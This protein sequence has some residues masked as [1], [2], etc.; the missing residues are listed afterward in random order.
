MSWNTKFLGRKF[1]LVKTET[2]HVDDFD[3]AW[4]LWFGC[5]DKSPL[6][7]AQ[8]PTGASSPSPP[9]ALP[10]R[11]QGSASTSLHHTSH[12]TASLSY[13]VAFPR[14][15][16]YTWKMWNAESLRKRLY[17]ILERDIMPGSDTFI[18]WRNC[19][20]QSNREVEKK[21]KIWPKLVKW[22]PIKIS[23]NVKDLKDGSSLLHCSTLG[24]V[25]VLGVG[26]LHMP[27]PVSSLALVASLLKHRN[28]PRKHFSRFFFVP[29]AL[30]TSPLECLL[31]YSV[32]PQ[33]LL[34]LGM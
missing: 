12:S 33:T 24:S 30:G 13:V 19:S 9:W 25:D 26:F 27:F 8:H 11:P 10:S 31:L 14:L 4:V 34:V 20:S 29:P 22:G 2:L 17:A 6:A 7:S 28:P 32:K 21:G 5:T 1:S 3:P 15:Q 16:T 23:N 18:W